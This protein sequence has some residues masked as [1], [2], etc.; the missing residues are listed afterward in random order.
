MIH[1]S[2]LSRFSRDVLLL[3]LHMSLNFSPIKKSYSFF[4]KMLRISAGDS[5][6][7]LF[8][9]RKPLIFTWF[10]NRISSIRLSYSLLCFLTLDFSPDII[11]H[12][13]HALNLYLPPFFPRIFTWLKYL[14]FFS[15]IFKILHPNKL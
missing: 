13:H 3:C 11:I 12:L 1:A 5:S 10:K 6:L 8:V 2:P 4:Q 14:H 15:S 9:S 7:R